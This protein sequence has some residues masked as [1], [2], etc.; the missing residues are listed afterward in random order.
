V[1]ELA[2]A[3]R[4]FWAGGVKFVVDEVEF[5]EYLRRLG[6]YG[7]AS[8]IREFE[9]LADDRKVNYLEGYRLYSGGAVKKFD[10]YG[11]PVESPPV[12]SRN[13]IPIPF[14]V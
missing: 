14:P 6:A 5:A 13:K 10:S 4:S 8:T 2:R 1:I 12:E 11:K 3:E 9:G 7:Y